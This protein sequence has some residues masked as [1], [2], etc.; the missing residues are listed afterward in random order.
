MTAA[1][2]G[3]G[4]FKLQELV[5]DGCMRLDKA[6]VRA[7]NLLPQPQDGNRNMSLY[8][9]LNKCKTPVGSRLLMRWVKQPLLDPAEINARLDLV[10][11]FFTDVQLRQAM[12]EIYLRHVPDL[13]RLA[14]KLQKQSKAT[15]M[16][17][18]RLYQFVQQLPQLRQALEECDA[19]HGELLA[20]R[21]T[22]PLRA[23]EADFKQY[24]RLVEQSLDLEGIDSHEYRISPRYSPDLKALAEQKEEVKADVEAQRGVAARKLGLADDKVK[25]ERNKDKIYT[26]RITRKDE[27]ALR[28]KA[29]TFQTL[30]TRKDGVK[31]TSREL[32][33]LAERYRQ[34]DD[35]YGAVQASL[36]AKVMEII[37]SYAPAV[38]Q[39]CDVVAE[40]DVLVALA[41]VASNAPTPYV[42]PALSAAG[43]GDLVLREARH[44]CVEMMDDVA[45]IA[46]DVELRRKDAR[47]QVVTGPNMGGKSTYIRQ[48]G[49]IVLMAQIGSFVP[50]SEAEVPVCHAIH[51]RIGA[52][53]N[54]VKGVS[55]FMQEMLDTAAIL[56]A[57][58][59]KSL[60]IIDEL[61]RGTSTYDG[62][63]LA[64]AI[65]EHICTEIRAPCLFATHF[66]ELTE[67]EHAAP[68]VANR[69]VT[70]HVEGGKLTMLYQVRAGACDQ[71]FGIHVAEMAQFP[72]H[73]V[74]MAKR[75]A[76]ELETFASAGGAGAEEGAAEGAGGSGS[77]ETL[78]KRRTDADA[79][80][81]SAEDAAGAKLVLNFLRD[82]AALPLEGLPPAEACAKAMALRDRV[83][84][85]NNSFV[86]RLLTDA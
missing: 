27:K 19:A 24:E 5:L 22:A 33:P 16:D 39:L 61:G 83:A 21:V 6:A 54:Q 59:D 71:S 9:L 53:D 45:F 67:L 12:Q 72:P 82:F 44:P 13:A 85:E 47:L 43:E 18:W 62:F 75:K 51:A 20:S 10:E 34:L 40:L 32:K 57:A 26:F 58:D 38:E 84:A 60:V 64:W 70:A 7:L 42:R 23:L 2:G 50:C 69:H 1:R 52:G 79:P 30:E 68:A 63:G 80:A 86:Q 56:G 78:K 3:A 36:V 35:E 37:A 25:L 11:T 41:H 65:S 8:A 29:A 66:H 17:A 81:R 28:S 4:R 49:V 14:R 77:P 74:A 46:N 76:A 15:L 73:V 55:T 48:A 31:F